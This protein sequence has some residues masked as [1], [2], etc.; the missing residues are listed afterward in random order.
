MRCMAKVRTSPLHEASIQ[1]TRILHD[2]GRELPL[3]RISA[4]I[5]QAELARRL[6][7]SQPRIS[8]FERAKDVRATLE[9]LMRHAA[10][11]G[12]RLWVRTYP[13]IRRVLDEPQLQLLQRL[14]DRIAAAW[15]WELEVPVPIPGDLRARDARIALGE[16]TILVEAITRLADIQ[17]QTRAAQL[18]RRDLGATRLVLLVAATETNLRALRAAGPAFSDAFPDPHR[19][20][21]A[22]PGQGPRPGRR[23]PRH[24]LTPLPLIQ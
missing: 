19:G 16:L 10:I 5:S 9:Q 21:H 6:D 3:A 17:A 23:R 24:P 14:R 18:T 11:L 12:L 15:N 22:R 13:A 2:L 1:A 4:G 20:R 8:R 7:T